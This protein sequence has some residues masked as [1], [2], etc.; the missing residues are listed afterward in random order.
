V[1]L[2]H[3]VSEFFSNALCRSLRVLQHAV[4]LLHYLGLARGPTDDMRN[5]LT[6]AVGGLDYMFTVSI[7]RLAY[8]D[9]PVTL[10][11]ETRDGIK[12][13]V[14]ALLSALLL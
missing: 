4:H 12:K 11:S 8:A 5:R 6:N 10:G 9:P 1:S 13:L 2:T 14:G 3:G 7:G